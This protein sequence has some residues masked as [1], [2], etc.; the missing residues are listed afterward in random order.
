[1]NITSAAEA[2]NHAVSPESMCCT[3]HPPVG[4]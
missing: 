3:A 4:R 2:S 1:M